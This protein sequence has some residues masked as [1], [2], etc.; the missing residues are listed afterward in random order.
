M[1]K[2]QK[3]NRVVSWKIF[4]LYGLGNILGAG[5]YVL[6]GEVASEAGSAL[7]WSF[8]LAGIVASLTAMTY[9]AL[10][11]QYPVSAGAAVYTERAF[12]NKNLSLG[13]GLALAFTGIIS[14]SALLRGFD[15]YF[16]ELLSNL[17]LLDGKI[18]AFVAILGLLTILSLVAFRGIKESAILAVILTLIEVGGLLIIIAVAGKYGD[19][20]MAINQSFSSLPDISPIAIMLGAFLA[21]YAFIGFEDMVNMAEE[22]KEP[23]TSIKKGMMLALLVATGLYILVSISALAVLSASQLG[24]SQAPLSEVFKQATSSS[25]PVISLIGVFAVTNGILAQ[26]IM[27]SR[28]LYGLAREGWLHKSMLVISPKNHTP[29]YATLLTVFVIAVASLLFPLATLAKITSFILLIIFSIVHISALKLIQKNDL[30]L[31][32]AIP[33]LGLVL[34]SGLII[35]QILNWI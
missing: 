29:T 18:P 17:E 6:I 31:S 11:S 1:N 35:L 7:I 16:Q 3:L 34:N 23:K 19:V 32:P 33:L 5:I 24:E 27:S 2:K 22:I 8:I 12:K 25:L 20:P 15:R 21:F 26:I 13:I 4:G 30:P 9:S 28:V 14:A 10:A